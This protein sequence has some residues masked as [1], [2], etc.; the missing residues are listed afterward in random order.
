MSSNSPPPET[1]SDAPESA[2]LTVLAEPLVDETAGNQNRLLRM[3]IA[4]L[5]ELIAH[6]R[7]SGTSPHNSGCP[8]TLQQP[9]ESGQ[10]SSTDDNA[11]ARPPSHVSHLSTPCQ[12]DL[13]VLD[14]LPT[15]DLLLWYRQH[16]ER[17]IAPCTCAVPATSTAESIAPFIYSIGA[18]GASMDHWT[19]RNTILILPPTAP[20]TKRLKIPLHSPSR[21]TT[22]DMSEACLRFIGIRWPRDVCRSSWFQF[23]GEQNTSS[24][25]CTLW[26]FAAADKLP[27]ISVSDIFMCSTSTGLRLDALYLRVF[28]RDGWVNVAADN[29]PDTPIEP[30]NSLASPKVKMGQIWY[31]IDPQ[32]HKGSIDSSGN[33]RSRLKTVF[34][35]VLM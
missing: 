15:S 9:P 28:R 1:T 22:T 20:H 26:H 24:P 27:S 31:G 33:V 16:L 6:L 4:D 17:A 23:P 11:P 13:A 3:L 18:E 21:S 34:D 8:R 10:R 29:L 12:E 19:F 7:A 30:P 25:E 35:Q 2:K 5:R 32:S 14:R